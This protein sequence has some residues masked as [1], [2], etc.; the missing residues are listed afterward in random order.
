MILQAK[1][2]KAEGL[3]CGEGFQAMSS[4]GRRA[5]RGRGNEHMMDFQPQA[6]S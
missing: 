4:H 6:L 1:K 5:K 3:A 2:S